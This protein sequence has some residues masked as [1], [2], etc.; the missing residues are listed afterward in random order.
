VSTLG[1]GSSFTLC[2]LFYWLGTGCNQLS[3]E[4]AEIKST[5]PSPEQV[6][7]RSKLEQLLFDDISSRAASEAGF[8]GAQA[9]HLALSEAL[10]QSVDLTLI[11][12][13]QK[14]IFAALT[15]PLT[16]RTQTDEGHQLA[17]I[18]KLSHRLEKLNRERRSLNDI[19]PKIFAKVGESP[20]N[21][22]QFLN[23]V[24]Q[25][26]AIQARMNPFQLDYASLPSLLVKTFHLPSNSAFFYQAQDASIR[27]AVDT[28]PRLTFAEAEIVAFMTGLPGQHFF[29]QLRPKPRLFPL[30]IEANE[31]AM[32]LL[33][34]ELANAFEYYRVDYS[35]AV[36]LDY[37]RLH[38]VQQLKAYQPKMVLGE[39]LGLLRDTNFDPARLTQ[40]FDAVDETA[41]LHRLTAEAF[42]SL[43]SQFDQSAQ[44]LPKSVLRATIA[45][46]IPILRLPLNTATPFD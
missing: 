6:S 41:T 14:M 4:R 40:A 22:Q 8:I 17:M 29:K 1:R 26:I 21:Q 13:D 37:L 16:H 34:L 15:N 44:A 30:H 45:D 39:F 2:L 24:Q 18:S 33:L 35:Q 28:L 20:A 3:L 7:L 19:D 36:R 9:Q 27:V 32:I 43:E 10:A 5:P 23:L 12:P 46:I 38:T 42:F 31:T 11:R 25:A